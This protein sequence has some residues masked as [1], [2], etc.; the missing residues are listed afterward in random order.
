MAA[1]PLLGYLRPQ[2]TSEASAPAGSHLSRYA[3]CLV[4]PVS[5]GDA[6]IIDRE[7]HLA[8]RLARQ[9]DPEP[10]HIEE[11]A[12]SFAIGWKGLYRIEGG[13]TD[14]DTGRNKTRLA[15]TSSRGLKI[16]NI[17]GDMRPLRP[18]IGVIAAA[19]AGV[20]VLPSVQ[21]AAGA[22]SPSVA[23]LRQLA[24]R[25]QYLIAPQT[26]AIQLDAKVNSSAESSVPQASPLAPL[27]TTAGRAGNYAPVVARMSGSATLNVDDAGIWT[28]VSGEITA[29]AAAMSGQL[30]S[31]PN[32]RASSCV[33]GRTRYPNGSVLQW[34]MQPA[35]GQ[36]GCPMGLLFT[37]WICS[38]GQWRSTIL[39]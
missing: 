9:G 31:A 23:V 29:E 2:A 4:S 39:R 21:S 3:V 13:T 5:L 15:T 26:E 19:L 18:T 11:I 37:P 16:S 6:W 14:R 1:P 10:F 33:A 30:A 32:P 28:N 12:T 22:Q 34:C 25:Q 27:A 36:V 20:P 17:Y 7:D 8:L 24:T 35:A 38:N